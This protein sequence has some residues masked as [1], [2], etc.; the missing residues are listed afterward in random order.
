MLVSALLTFQMQRK[1][2][3]LL[4]FCSYFQT[5]CAIERI[6][7]RV[8]CTVEYKF[9]VENHENIDI[10]YVKYNIKKIACMK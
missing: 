1:G 3:N 8:I 2:L 10:L 5:L 6:Q 4:G 7:E 9:L